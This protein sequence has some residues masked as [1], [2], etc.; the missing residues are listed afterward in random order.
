MDSSLRDIFEKD[1]FE[2]LYKSI[3]D[4]SADFIYIVDFEGNVIYLNK[5]ARDYFERRGVDYKNI[6][7]LSFVH[8]DDVPVAK[9]SLESKVDGKEKR[10][11][12]VIRVKIGDECKYYQINSM[13]IYKDGKP[14][15]V[16]GIARNVNDIYNTQNELKERSRELMFLNR[17]ADFIMNNLGEPDKIIKKGLD[18]VR[19][20][21]NCPAGVMYKI[22][23]AGNKAYAV[24]KYG[25]SKG[26]FERVAD[27]P[28]EE[29]QSWLKNLV[30]KEVLRGRDVRKGSFA[31]VDILKN[32]GYNDFILALAS[33]NKIPYAVILI[34][35]KDDIAISRDK[36]RAF[37]ALVKQLGTGIA[38]STAHYDLV[39]SRD[40]LREA[41]QLWEGTFNV[42]KDA[43]IITDRDGN[44]LRANRSTSTVLGLDSEDIVGKNV[45]D[46]AV[47]WCEQCKELFN[48]VLLTG[49]SRDFEVRL[50]GSRRYLVVT[51]SPIY[52]GME[53]DKVLLVIKDITELRRMWEELAQ[54]QKL[55]SIG[56]LASGISHNFNNILMS[57]MG[58]LYQLESVLG[59]DVSPLVKEIIDSIESAV[60]DAAETI[61][62]LLLFARSAEPKRQKF[63]ASSLLKEIEFLKK[64][65][66][67]NISVNFHLLTDNPWVLGDPGQIKQSL[68]NLILNAKDAMPDGGNIDV[69]ISRKKVCEGE[70]SSLKPGEYVVISVR[71]E[72]IGIPPENLD[73]IFDPFF[74]TKKE[75]KGTGLGLSM[76]YRY[77]TGMGGVVEVESRVGE[78]TRFDL[79]IPAT[80]PPE[81]KKAES[82][83]KFHPARVLIIEDD[84]ALSKLFHSYLTKEGYQVHAFGSAREALKHIEEHKP[85][86]AVMDAMLPDV[87]GEDLVWTITRK[88][89]GLPVIVVSGKKPAQEVMEILESGKGAFLQKPFKLPA[90]SQ[91]IQE[92]VERR[93]KSSR[94][95]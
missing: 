8:P 67:S 16:Q 22:D 33:H 53:I 89:P 65:F 45:F 21:L 44:I 85:D 55:E 20:F 17:F 2:G 50:P 66:P 77:I 54:A 47:G 41:N 72:G 62:Q 29:E 25:I 76:V 35:D 42:V 38:L 75:G 70:I 24:G 23:F 9:K 36:L 57:I 63:D 13:V 78:G 84:P 64:A 1:D 56:F 18:Y 48:Q 73:K 87:S 28:F 39:K 60:D 30:D 86:I 11:L 14:Y 31:P 51:I 58:N 27:V 91:K 43:I 71:D 10:N 92:L 12:Y 83:R 15:A 69:I 90:L 95:N 32:E 26:I 59:D 74:T 46:E 93:K 40:S 7:L 34:A 68:I 3:V 82:D 19:H 80:S 88:F 37:K 5:T 79:Y 52:R 49:E 81:R 6:N 61:Q 4:N 94:W